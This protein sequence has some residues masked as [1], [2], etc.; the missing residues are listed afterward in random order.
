[1]FDDGDDFC[2]PTDGDHVTTSE[3]ADRQ[4]DDQLQNGASSGIEGDVAPL[5]NLEDEDGYH[6]EVRQQTEQTVHT[7]ELV[8][9]QPDGSDEVRNTLFS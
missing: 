7:A 6:V 1:M 2:C 9:E 8:H 3:S 4:N 5:I